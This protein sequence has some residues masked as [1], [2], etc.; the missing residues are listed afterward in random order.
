MGAPEAGDMD[1][2]EEDVSQ[3]DCNCCASKSTIDL[4][5]S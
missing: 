4:E 5:G 2:A 1:A 3:A